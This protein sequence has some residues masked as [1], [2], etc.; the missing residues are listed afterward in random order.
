M[1]SVSVENVGGSSESF[2]RG[3][4]LSTLDNIQ[5][6]VQ[7]RGVSAGSE[8]RN[9]AQLVLSGTR[10]GKIYKVPNHQH[11]TY[12]ASAPGEAPANRLGDFSSSWSVKTN[13]SN[14]SAFES[15]P[16]IESAEKSKQYLIGD[17][18]EEG[19]RHMAPRAYKEKVVEK[20]LPYINAIYSRPYF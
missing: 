3:E 15:T 6:Q 16:G 7:G 4:V 2:L 17:I 8:L 20:A 12:Q 5:R 14:G 13:I 19:T 9:A 18:L 11:A 10:S 1:I